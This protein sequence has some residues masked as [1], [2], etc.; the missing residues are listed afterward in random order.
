MNAMTQPKPRAIE[1]RL[2]ARPPPP[3]GMVLNS[4][5]DY[6]PASRMKPQLKLE[7]QLVET[8]VT[9]AVQLREE[10]AEFR[11]QAFS[12]VDQFL[13]LLAEQYEAERGGK[14]GNTT[15]LSY[16]GLLKVQV[17]TG[18]F[19]TFGPEL[20]VAKGLVDECLRQWTEG[21]NDNIKAIVN[22]A[23]DVGSQG[24]IK[25]DRVLGL[26][27]LHIED[28]TWLRAMTAI[29]DAIRTT[30]SKRYVRFYHRETHDGEWK[31]ISLDLSR[32][33]S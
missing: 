1:P 22:D 7:D 32:V 3:E 33:S 4:Y 11:E 13:A 30:H 6:T 26:R 16:D 2:G 12:D 25:V 28:A 24:R 15:L 21:S 14:T 5:G 20:Q 9:R 31:Q 18:D 19:L 29:S 17:A 23:F 27:R 10:M 8:L